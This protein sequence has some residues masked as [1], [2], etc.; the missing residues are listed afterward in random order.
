MQGMPS[1]GLK[2][3]QY[4]A[5]RLRWQAGHTALLPPGLLS[6]A[7][8]QQPANL[9]AWSNACL[10]G[11]DQ[12]MPAVC[13]T[14]SPPQQAVAEGIAC[15]PDWRHLRAATEAPLQQKPDAGTCVLVAPGFRLAARLVLQPVSSCSV[16]TP[17]FGQED[18]LDTTQCASWWSAAPS[19]LVGLEELTMR[20]ILPCI[21]TQ[22]TAQP[23]AAA[24]R[25]T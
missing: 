23:A 8:C 16:R 18:S 12:A 17:P 25:D 4:P 9:V 6:L 19:L 5:R 3:S 14:P 10:S 13:W 15:A 22:S 20:A 21:C 24:G 11:C 2:E 7:M 1:A